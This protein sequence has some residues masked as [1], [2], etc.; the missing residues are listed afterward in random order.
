M[1]DDVV[2][3]I[4]EL[5]SKLAACEKERD[6]ADRRAGAAERHAEYQSERIGAR[7]QW[8]RD[9]KAAW[10]VDDRVSFDVVWKE[11]LALRSRLHTAETN[12]SN[13]KALLEA[14]VIAMRSGATTEDILETVRDGVGLTKETPRP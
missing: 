6:E 3:D 11:A 12:L 9:A 14:F 5:E 4:R 7:E 13:A 2:A 10:G 1:Q 8:L